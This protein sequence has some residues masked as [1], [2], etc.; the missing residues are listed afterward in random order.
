MTE[1]FKEIRPDKIEFAEKIYKDTL[2]TI[3]Q[4]ENKRGTLSDDFIN[5]ELIKLNEIKT[6]LEKELELI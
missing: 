3:I 2:K 4:I 5:K 6:A 1:S